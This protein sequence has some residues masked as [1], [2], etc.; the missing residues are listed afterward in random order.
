M[1]AAIKKDSSLALLKEKLIK[2][3]NNGSNSFFHELIRFPDVLSVEISNNNKWISILYTDSCYKIY[4]TADFEIP[5][6]LKK[7][8]DTKLFC[9]SPDGNLVATKNSHGILKLW[10]L[11]TG[12]CFSFPTLKFISNVEISTDNKWII[13][14]GESNVKVWEVVEGKSPE[15]LTSQEINFCDISYDSKI[16]LT[17][18]RDSIKLWSLKDRKK[19]E[20]FQLEV[21]YQDAVY[22]YDSKWLIAKKKDSINLWSFETGKKYNLSQNGKLIRHVLF[23]YDSKWLILTNQ[24][25]S[26]DI[27]DIESKKRPEFLKEEGEIRI[28][29]ASPDNKWLL[30]ENNNH[31][32]NLWSLINGQK[33]NIDLSESEKYSIKSAYYSNDS[34]WLIIK[35]KFS[36]QLTIYNLETQKKVEYLDNEYHIEK[37]KISSDNNWLVLD[38]LNLLANKTATARVCNIETGQTPNFLSK[39]GVLRS[40]IF[41]QNSR[42]LITIDENHIAKIWDV[43]AF[44]DKNF[45]QMQYNIWGFHVAKNKKWLFC[46]EGFGGSKGIWSLENGNSPQFLRNEQIAIPEIVSDDNKWLVVKD[47]EFNETIWSIDSGCI[48]PYLR[49]ENWIRDVLFSD[50][51]KW[52]ITTIYGP[53]AKIW[54]LK[55]GVNPEFLEKENIKQAIFYNSNNIATYN[56]TTIKL[57]DMENGRMINSYNVE[58]KIYFDFTTFSKDNKW[59]ILSN[60]DYTDN[61]L[62]LDSFLTP[63][64]LQ[65]E[66]KLKR[67]IFSDDSKWLLTIGLDKKIILWDVE[68]GVPVDF[69]K[70]EKNIRSATFSHNSKSLLTMNNDFTKKVWTLPSGKFYNLPFKKK[71]LDAVEFSSDDKFIITNVEKKY[72]LFFSENG[73][74]PN[75]LNISGIDCY[76]YYPEDNLIAIGTNKTIQIWNVIQMKIVNTIYLNKTPTQIAFQDSSTILVSSGKALLRFKILHNRK[77]FSYGDGELNFSYDEILNWIKEFGN[78]FMKLNSQVKNKYNVP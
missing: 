44:N 77:Y 16:L 66:N 6:Y 5:A 20:L 46:S 7:E 55:N 65:K 28:L 8:K 73:N 58:E 60:Q 30:T 47:G 78:H 45:L 74:A 68:S 33:Q 36:S 3:F 37:Y 69:L 32:C 71:E 62:L 25:G 50:N 35:N 51:N 76:A 39:E 12:K 27:W 17:A 48:V 56:D 67:A 49:D 22:S 13:I 15:F 59:M 19:Y 42:F 26:G 54:N 40:A 75:F 18:N 34:K 21:G 43:K 41:S 24:D 57:W 10:M 52:L 31:K 63:L 1:Q 23:S 14:T 53:V 11:E 4:S 9:F 38:N 72:Y 29:I 64:F 2:I 70:F 61:V